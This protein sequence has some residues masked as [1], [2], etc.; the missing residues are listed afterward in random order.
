MPPLGN[1]YKRIETGTQMRI[2]RKQIRQLI[3]EEITSVLSEAQFYRQPASPGVKRVRVMV[4]MPDYPGM[5]ASASRVLGDMG[6]RP[7]SIG[8]TTEQ[9]W[10]NDNFPAVVVGFKDAAHRINKKY[11][12][13]YDADPDGITTSRDADGDGRSDSEELRD[14]ARGIDAKERSRR[15][16]VSRSEVGDEY[17]WPEPGRGMEKPL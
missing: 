11:L 13:L 12:V 16:A 14:I 8:D 15:D 4:K 6:V 7:G 1:S 3:K 17:N 5:R 9:A 10:N 2:T